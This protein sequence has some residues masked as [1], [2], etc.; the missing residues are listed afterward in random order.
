MS[1]V[2][3]AQIGSVSP[4]LENFSMD[5]A[6]FVFVKENIYIK[7]LRFVLFVMSMIKYVLRK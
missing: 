3:F 4:H 6:S 5:K 7:H 1:S 2:H